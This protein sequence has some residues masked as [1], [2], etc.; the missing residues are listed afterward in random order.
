M[1][2]AEFRAKRKELGLSQQKLAD[3][4]EMSRMAISFYETGI[5]DIPRRT[6]L[7]MICLELLDEAD[8]KFAGINE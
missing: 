4:L 8:K 6:E 2:A 7:A 1:N 5:V 3:Q